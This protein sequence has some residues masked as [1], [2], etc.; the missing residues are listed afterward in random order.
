MNSTDE[1]HEILKPPVRCAVIGLGMGRAHAHSFMQCEEA[2]LVA[3]ADLDVDRM[4]PFASDVGDAGLFTDSREM[5]KHIQPDLVMV[6]LPNYLHK[7]VTLDALE[8]GAH[9][10]CEKP[11]AMTV[12]EAEAMHA[13][14]K[15]CNRRLGINFSQ[16]FTPA[17]RALKH[18]ADSGTLGD[19]YHG[20][21]S[22]TRRDS[23]PR[24]GGW[25][26][27]K[28]M[29]GGGP[30]IDL[31]V[32]RIDLSMWL[33]G[34]PKVVSVSGVIHHRIGVPRGREHGVDFDVEDFATGLV[35][36]ENG[37]SLVLEVSWAGH[38]R[39]KETQLMRI[40]GTE[41]ALE[42]DRGYFHYSRRG[43][44]FCATTIDVESAKARNS[45]QEMVHCLVTGQPFWGSPEQG[46]NIQRIL[47]GL[48]ESAATGREVGFE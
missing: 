7:Q 1:K 30:L 21:C 25:F 24:F 16:R 15:A 33:M 42:M 38:Q 14:A 6:A 4:A 9:V 11:M 12:A 32:H 26:G 31:G 48:Y 36:F 44:V 13:A 39:E 43:D 2:S 45:V 47:N 23:I 22:W 41:G 18:L 17:H 10:I 20:Y 8:A 37:A 29:S 34:H 28:E 5:L 35:R 46:I 19:I 3:V 27:Q 40:M